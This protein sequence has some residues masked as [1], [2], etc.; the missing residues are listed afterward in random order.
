M[1]YNKYNRRFTVA[2]LTTIQNNKPRQTSSMGK[3][4]HKLDSLRKGLKE[5]EA[6]SKVTEQC[7]CGNNNKSVECCDISL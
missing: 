5:D 3:T 6:T 4:Q 7:D 1:K 2:K